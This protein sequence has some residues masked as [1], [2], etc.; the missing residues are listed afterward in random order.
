MA[1]GLHLPIFNVAE[2]EE[3]IVLVLQFRS[4]VAEVFTLRG[5]TYFL[6]TGKMTLGP[7]VIIL[8]GNDRTSTSSHKEPIKVRALPLAALASLARYY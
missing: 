8:I 5:G 2:S 3:R 7:H 6:M 1:Q 4:K